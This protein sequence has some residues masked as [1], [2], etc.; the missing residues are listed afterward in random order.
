M[1]ALHKCVQSHLPHALR[2]ED[3]KTRELLVELPAGFDKKPYVIVSEEVLAVILKDKTVASALDNKLLKILDEV[4]KRYEDAIDLLAAARTKLSDANEKLAEEKATSSQKDQK[5]AE[6]QAKL[7]DM[8]DAEKGEMSP[9]RM[10]ELLARR[11]ALNG[12]SEEKK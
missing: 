11:A 12:S 8:E 6:L 5:I 7:K 4:P 2:L 10:K 9:D 1:E 3:P